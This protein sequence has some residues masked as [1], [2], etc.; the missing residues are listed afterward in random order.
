MRGRRACGRKPPCGG[1]PGRAG[2]GGALNTT[3][4]PA[5]AGGPGGT[6]GTDTPGHDAVGIGETA[7]AAPFAM[8]FL[9]S[10]STATGRPSCSDTSWATSGIRDEPPTSSTASSWSGTSPA[11]TTA[12]RSAET[13]SSTCGR[14]SA[15]NSL[16]CSRTEPCVD[17]S[18][19]GIETSVSLLS[20]SLASVHS[21]RMRA[22]ADSTAGSVSSR[23]ANASG[24][25]SSTCRKTASSKSMPPSRSRPSGRPSRVNAGPPAPLPSPLRTTAASNVPPPRS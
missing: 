24:M 9:G 10:A 3:V 18:R 7:S 22:T 14:I 16:R 4:G 2:R 8:A 23:P 25:P 1:G 15:S 11:E 21:R 12:P 20:A 19:T 13:V 6:G 5:G 17:G